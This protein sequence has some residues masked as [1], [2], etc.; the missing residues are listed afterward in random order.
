MPLPAPVAPR[1]PGAASVA[2][3]LAQ[4]RAAFEAA[5]LELVDVGAS[6]V[7]AA[8]PIERGLPD[9]GKRARRWSAVGRRA[10]RGPRWAAATGAYLSIAD[11]VLM[12]SGQAPSGKLILFRRP[13]ALSPPRPHGMLR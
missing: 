8:N 3:P 2:R 1:K 7:V 10:R 12:R 4:Y 9:Y 5:G 13:A 6:T 11:R